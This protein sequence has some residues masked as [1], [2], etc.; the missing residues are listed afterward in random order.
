[1]WLSQ[2]LKAKL[3]TNQELQKIQLACQQNNV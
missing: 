2:G 1:M 3:L